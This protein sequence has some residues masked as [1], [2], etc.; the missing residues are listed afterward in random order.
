MA[1]L[2]NPLEEGKMTRFQVLRVSLFTLAVMV[3]A[4]LANTAAFAL[5]DPK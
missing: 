4:L 1:T 2:G 5:S 3:S